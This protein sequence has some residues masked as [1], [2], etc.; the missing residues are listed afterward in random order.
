MERE[1]LRGDVK[2]KLQ[3]DELHEGKYQCVKQGRSG[4]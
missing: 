4:P 2:G 1:N 3:V